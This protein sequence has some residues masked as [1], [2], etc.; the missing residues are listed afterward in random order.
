M[1]CV[2]ADGDD[3]AVVGAEKPLDADADS[4]VRLQM[5]TWKPAV[6]RK[7]DQLSRQN[8]PTVT[9]SDDDCVNQSDPVCNRSA[10]IS[11][12]S[13][14]RCDN[15]INYSSSACGISSSVK[16]AGRITTEKHFSSSS[17]KKNVGKARFDGENI[18]DMHQQQGR[19]SLSDL[20]LVL[21]DDIYNHSVNSALERPRSVGLKRKP[22]TGKLA[23]LL[24]FLLLH[25]YWHIYVFCL[26]V[27]S[28]HCNFF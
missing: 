4:F 2:D 7:S 13:A 20:G 21:S 23:L 1:S 19:C 22:S 25:C 10:K 27:I 24:L 12:I 17:R 3:D 16:N 6:Q 18:V 26:I 11:Q 5:A 8:N 15:S 28:D 14:K 9:V